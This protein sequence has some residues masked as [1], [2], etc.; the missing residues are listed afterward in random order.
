MQQ[1]P[2]VLA[3]AVVASYVGLLLGSPIAVG[4]TQRYFATTVS[5]LPAPMV[6]FTGA[7]SRLFPQLVFAQAK[8]AGLLL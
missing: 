6:V 7:L 5:Q 3:V 2:G 8:Q 1:Y 4:E